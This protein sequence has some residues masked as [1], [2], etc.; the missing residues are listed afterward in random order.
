[1]KGF[2]FRNNL[3]N[4]FAK[5]T[6]KLGSLLYSRNLFLAET[7]L[8]EVTY[9]PTNNENNRSKRSELRHPGT[10]LTALHSLSNFKNEEFL[11]Q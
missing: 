4:K 11:L 6:R 3:Q 10:K 2:T 8:K 1:M 7:S 5:H 9:W